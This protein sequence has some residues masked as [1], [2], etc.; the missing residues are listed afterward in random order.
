MTQDIFHLDWIF[1]DTIII[2]LLILLLLAVKLYKA[3]HRWRFSF[4]NEALENSYYRK[5]PIKINNPFISSFNWTL[6]KNTSLSEESDKK[7]II[8]I[9]RT[10]FKK[11]LLYILTE[12]L[13][14][15]GFNIINLRLKLNNH[16]S[17]NLFDKTHLDDVRDQITII[18]DFFKEK[19][20]N[21]NYNYILINY[22]K[23]F[24]CYKS[25]LTDPKNYGMILINPKLNN[26]NI[27]NY[28]DLIN[29]HQQI[30]QLFTIFS[31]KSIFILNNRNLKRFL[32][33]FYQQN[34]KKLNLISIEKAKY[35]FK[36][37]ETILLGMIINLI[38]SKLLN[39]KN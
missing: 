31:K 26:E 24:I 29:S 7:P 23:S 16:K 25:I 27:K 30:S 4:S 12:G 38:E 32:I 22:S 17:Y 2:I 9:L 6:T 21:S 20:L 34:Q 10:N 39:A 37:Y 18:L 8:M 14:S 35:S 33:Q 19:D 5:P 1:I 15:Y 3:T 11:K 13:C 36:Y 28:N